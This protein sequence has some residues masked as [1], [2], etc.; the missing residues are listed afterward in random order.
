[1]AMGE[2]NVVAC[3]FEVR[4]TCRRREEEMIVSMVAWRL[5]DWWR[6]RYTDT[7]SLEAAAYD[8][9]KFAR[10]CFC[11]CDVVAFIFITWEEDVDMDGWTLSS[12]EQ[13]RDGTGPSLF[14]RIEIARG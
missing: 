7:E 11:F 10:V 3:L 1:M 8:Y 2:N 6:A 9:D 12:G 14:S 4:L 13:R 5:G